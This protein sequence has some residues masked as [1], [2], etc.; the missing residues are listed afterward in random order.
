[1]KM[2]NVVRFESPEQREVREAL[3]AIE[4][5]GGVI[6]GP[7]YAFTRSDLSEALDYVLVNPEDWKGPIDQVIPKG[8]LRITE[9][10]CEF[11]TATTLTVF[12][13]DADHVRVTSEGYRDGPAGDH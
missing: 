5:A 1:M 9:V 8:A 10:A 12:D 7:D 4:E 2:G 6:S 11:F 3:D 13:I